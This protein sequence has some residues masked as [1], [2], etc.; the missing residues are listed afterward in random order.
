MR[1]YIGTKVV[2]AKPMTFAEWCIYQNNGSVA[3]ESNGDDPGYLVEYT[4][5]GAANHPDHKGYVSWS[6]K[7]VFEE[8]YHDTK[9]MTFS[10][11]LEALRVGKAVMRDIF[12]PNT[13]LIPVIDDNRLVYI[14]MGLTGDV[15]MEYVPTLIDIAATDWSLA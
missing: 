13:K 15:G 8:S 11:A 10:Q 6:P 9:R 7:D 14:V 5:G 3:D 2:L 1:K 12:E 4:N